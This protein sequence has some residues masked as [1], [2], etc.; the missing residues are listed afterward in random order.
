MPRKRVLIVDDAPDDREIFAAL[1]THFGYHVQCA[2]DGVLGLEHFLRAP[3]DLVLLDLCMPRMSGYEVLDAIR[4]RSAAGPPVVA[5]TASVLHPEPERALRA[6]F[7]AFVPKPCE[8][9]DLLALVRHL[10]GDPL[11]APREL[12]EPMCR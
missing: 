4:S 2:E 11:R 10:I 8:P 12:P 3:P 9:R 5:V 7:T 1:L 6:G